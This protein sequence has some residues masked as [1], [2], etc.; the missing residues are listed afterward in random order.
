MFLFILPAGKSRG[1]YGCWV[2]ATT[3]QGGAGQGCV[4]GEGMTGM[5]KTRF[6]RQP[7]TAISGLAAQRPAKAFRSPPNVAFT[8]LLR[9]P[10][11]L[12]RSLQ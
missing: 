9:D 10:S 8:P 1:S 7:D 12:Q 3:R 11:E 6:G 5:R 4:L 2:A